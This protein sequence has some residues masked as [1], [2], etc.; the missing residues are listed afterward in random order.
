MDKKIELIDLL[1][2]KVSLQATLMIRNGRGVLA[3]FYFNRP[4][5]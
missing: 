3:G 1:V 2:N 4:G 5:G